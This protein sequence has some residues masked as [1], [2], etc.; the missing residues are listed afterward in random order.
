MEEQFTPE[1]QA[2]V[3]AMENEGAQ[4]VDDQT[5]GAQPEEGKTEPAEAK[6]EAPAEG[7][8]GDGEQPEG[9]Q[10]PPEGFVPHGALHA[11]R[12][13]RK[14]LQ[15]E[16]AELKAWREAQEKPPEAEPQYVDPIEDPEGF[17]K[18]AEHRE[19]KRE[20]ATRQ[21]QESAQQERARQERFQEVTR[22]EQEFAAK[23]PDYTDAVQHLV[24]TRQ[25]E[26]TAQGYGPQE[27]QQQMQKDANGIFDAARAAGM[28][29]AELL[30]MRA[31]SAGYTGPQAQQ[32]ADQTGQ[33][34]QA[35]ERAQKATQSLGHGG[36][37]KQSGKL[38]ASQL[39]D[40]SEAEFAKLSEDDIRAAMGG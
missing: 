6:T 16:I 38:T 14:Q 3:D 33:Q 23:T 36:G 13:A 17:R 24:Q 11:E 19:A 4:P 37:D 7:E 40:M 20:E 31:R 25:Q 35:Q 8:Q 39:A 22:Y 28:N 30:Y 2:A 15:K 5:G 12:E 9:K 10:K 26:L 34:L 18:W 29:P 27:I 21:Q 1:E 32:Q